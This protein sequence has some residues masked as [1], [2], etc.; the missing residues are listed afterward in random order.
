VAH[1]VQGIH[2]KVADEEHI[3][4]FVT[5][6]TDIAAVTTRLT[7]ESVPGAQVPCLITQAVDQLPS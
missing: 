7:E 4:V 1:T 5:G 2:A 6:K 3:L